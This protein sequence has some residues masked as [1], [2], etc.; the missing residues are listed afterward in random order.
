MPLDDDDVRKL[1]DQLEDEQRGAGLLHI[2]T[3][4]A[5]FRDQLLQL[6]FDRAESFILARDMLNGLMDCLPVEVD[7]ER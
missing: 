4:T 3:T 7:D 5:R 2:A 1:F 6:G